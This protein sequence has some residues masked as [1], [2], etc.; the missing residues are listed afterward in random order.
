LAQ[1]TSLFFFADIYKTNKAFFQDSDYYTDIRHQ[2]EST[3]AC[4]TALDPV[5]E[6]NGTVQLV[7]FLGQSLVLQAPAG[8]VLFMSNQLLHK[9]TGNSSKTFRRAYMA[10]YSKK[11]LLVNSDGALEASQCIGLAVKC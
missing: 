5:N 8:T 6:N 9:S 3:I 1:G 10:Q 2:Q 7:D 11:P 4:W